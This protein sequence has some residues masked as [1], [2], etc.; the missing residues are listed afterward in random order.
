MAIVGL[1]GIGLRHLQSLCEFNGALQ[2]YGIDPSPEARKRAVNLNRK[3]GRSEIVLIDCPNLKELKMRPE[4]AIV[5]TNARER[6]SV[7]RELCKLKCSLFLLEKILF[8]HPAEYE[9]AANL[10]N[11][12][13]PKVWVNCVRRCAP[14]FARLQGL[15]AGKTVS[16]RVAGAS[17]GLASNIVHHLDEWAFLCRAKDMTVS[18]KLD[19]RLIPTRRVGYYEVAGTI[20]AQAGPHT[21]E[22]RSGGTATAGEAGDRTIWIRVNDVELEIGQTSGQMIV[23][24]PDKN[25]ILEAYPPAL[26]SEATAKHVEAILAGLEPHLPRFEEAARLHLSVL[27]VLWP[28][29]QSLNPEFTDCPIT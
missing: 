22:A 8:S 6:L 15:T 7:V 27:E 21:F 10:F 25:A 2:I 23:T 17:W 20:R 11:G 4:L 26:Q 28:H 3:S 29:F 18:A 16:Y 13:R 19:P 5:A 12:H 24:G 14:R 9:E 1:G